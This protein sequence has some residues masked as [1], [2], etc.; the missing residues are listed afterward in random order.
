MNLNFEK[1]VNSPLVV[2]ASIINAAYTFIAYM[3]LV[4]TIQPY[5]VALI[6]T[7]IA[8]IL[9][10]IVNGVFWIDWTARLQKVTTDMKMGLSVLIILSLMSGI[11]YLASI[12]VS[13]SKVLI[14]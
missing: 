7:L 12:V 11:I 2:K 14:L 3:V 6:Y 13:T 8:Q 4:S 9:A 5:A 10:L 1:K